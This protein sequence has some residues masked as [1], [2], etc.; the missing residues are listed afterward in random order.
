MATGWQSHWVMYDHYGYAFLAVVGTGAAV[1]L[2]Q[3]SLQHPRLGPWL[4]SLGGVVPPFINVISVLFGLTL[5]FLA[6]D[7]WSARDRAVNA[8]MKSPTAKR[9]A[10]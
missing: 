8:V 7:T 1:L 6:N 9:K 10:L 3:R 2:V 4:A 5:A